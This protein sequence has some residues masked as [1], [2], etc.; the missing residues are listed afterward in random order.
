MILKDV[1]V[2]VIDND[3]DSLY[4][5]S[6]FLEECGADVITAVSIKEALDVFGWLLPDL[7]VCETRFWGES[8]NTL[9][10]KLSEMER[11]S[12]NHI[13]AIAVTT[14]I[15]SSLSQILDAGFEGY[16]LKPVDLNALVSMVE[17]LSLHDRIVAAVAV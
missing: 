9:T 14:W 10:A 13:P 1:Q 3:R 17:N 2:L 16:L 11:R 4:L 5:Y 8:I 7:V 6:I 15:T 12:K